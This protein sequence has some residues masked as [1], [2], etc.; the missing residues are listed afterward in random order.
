MKKYEITEEEKEQIEALVDD[1]NELL[2]KVGNMLSPNSLAW[3]TSFSPAKIGKMLERLDK[4]HRKLG[5]RTTGKY[6]A[7]GKTKKRDIY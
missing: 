6:K 2:D 5:I 4:Q 1:Y 3:G 7:R